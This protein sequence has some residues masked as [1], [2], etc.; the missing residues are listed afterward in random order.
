MV[1]TLAACAA[2]IIVTGTELLHARRSRRV[3]P[4]FF[5]P[6]GQPAPWVKAVP[7][8]RAAAVAAMTWGMVTLM[9]LTPKVHTADILPENE[10][11]HVLI[12][13]DV[14]PSMRLQ[15]S[16]PEGKQGRMQRASDVLAS[17]FRRVAIQQY[18][19]SV[20]AF[21]TGAKP[22]VVDTTDIDVVRNILSDLP[23]HYAFTAG[24]TDIFAGLKEA[25][26]I[27]HPWKPRSTTVIL[28]SDGETVSS[29]GIPKM[30]ASV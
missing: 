4:L 30:P 1:A 17:F 28:V 29:T 25:A 20:V 22:V 9:L 18:R 5:G 14:S 6:G 19:L 7:F 12:V 2:V 26:N 13:L 3:A 21:Y 23:M 15:D 11:Q 16:G 8:L 24:E 27:A 10:Y